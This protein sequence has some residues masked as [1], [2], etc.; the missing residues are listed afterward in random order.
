MQLKVFDGSGKGTNVEL[1]KESLIQL[2]YDVVV[3]QFPVYD[4]TIGRIISKYLKGESGDIKTV[5]VE[6]ITAAYA[7]D[8]ARFA[9]DIAMYLENG[10]IVICDRY[11]YSNVFNMV[12]EPKEKWDDF[13][14]WLE[15]L[16]FDC[17]N[18]IKPDYNIF[19]YV[20]YTVSIERIANRGKRN[21][22]DGKE[23]IHESNNELLKQASDGYLYISSKRD[24]WIIIDEMQDNKQLPLEDVFKKLFKEVIKI[25]KND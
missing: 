11:T 23:D 25:L 10:T 1:L 16:E 24:N 17:L 20:D 22:Q 7:A 15:D 13:L 6:L 19:L 5:P 18:V 12:K 3:Y 21:Y 8:R 14:S 4:S 2:G 9:E